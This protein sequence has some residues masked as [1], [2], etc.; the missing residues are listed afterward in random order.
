[1][2]DPGGNV[3][4]TQGN[5]DAIPDQLVQGREFDATSADVYDYTYHYKYF[6][7]PM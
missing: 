2:R 6:G 7:R 3:F 4:V 1:M 5:I